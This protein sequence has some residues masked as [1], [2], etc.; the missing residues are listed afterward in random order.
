MSDIIF[1]VAEFN[2]VLE[3]ALK[4]SER[5]YDK[6]VNGQALAVSLAALRNTEKANID[7]VAIE[8]GQIASRKT[9]KGTIKRVFSKSDEF[10]EGEVVNRAQALV[11]WMRKKRGEKPIWG[12]ELDNS[13]KGLIGARLSS[14]AFIKSGWLYS[15]R[16]LLKHAYGDQ[17]DIPDNAET[18]GQKKGYAI[19]A[20]PAINSV[21]MAEIANTSLIAESAARTGSRKGNPMPVAMRGLEIAFRLVS[22]DMMEHLRRK[23]KPVLNEFSSV[24]N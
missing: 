19:A 5:T 16:T 17:I 8:L 23:L 7:E 21:V 22:K 13:A 24:R 14:I 18:R 4:H 9:K 1:N 11:N 20:K 15:V 10:W 12:K 6:F 3:L 2:R